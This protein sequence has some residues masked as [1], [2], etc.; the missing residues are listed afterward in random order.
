ME[1]TIDV[2]ASG[3]LCLDLIPQMDHVPLAALSAP[4]KLYEIGPLAIST[5]GSVSNTGLALHRL[6]ANVRLMATV[7]DDLL[8]QIIIAFLRE[9]D[10]LLAE[11]IAVK[12]GHA[13]SYTI[14]LSPEKVDRLFLHCTGT[15]AVFSAEDIDYHLLAA[16]KCFHLG[17]PPILPALIANDGQK[18]AQL[19]RDAAQM[20]VLTSL[21]MALPDPGGASGRANWP[22]ILE[23]T[24]PHCDVFIPSLEEALFML[25]RRE[26]DLWAASTSQMVSLAELRA[27]ADEILALGPAIVGFKLGAFGIYIKTAPLSRMQAVSLE[28]FDCARWADREIYHPA[29]SA[30]VVGTTGAGDAAYGGFLLALLR[31][32]PPEECA[33]WACAVGACNVEAADA[34]S[35]VR[36]WDE[37]SARLAEGWPLSAQ[38][39]K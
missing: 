31:G 35:G 27:F 1:R 36:S 13:S 24:L 38:R 6:G 16:A 28:S 4:G 22:R 15:N 18:L 26:F 2:I 3:H 33:R 37:T 25:R 21:D 19:F 30:N 14:V 20:G 5:G 32:L 10:P 12:Q 34:T 9:R 8:G 29:F 17:Y 7:G 11:M 39:L 23:R